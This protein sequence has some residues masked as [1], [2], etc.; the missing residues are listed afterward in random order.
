M[1]GIPHALIISEAVNKS[2]L[3]QEM[4]SVG[5]PTKAVGTA[6][7]YNVLTANDGAK[8]IIKQKKMS[9]FIY[10]FIALRCGI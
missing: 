10:F 5:S 2:T 6:N 3:F 9:F 1:S 7:H 4:W 8:N